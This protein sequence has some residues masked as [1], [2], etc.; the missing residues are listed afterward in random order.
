MKNRLLLIFSAAFALVFASLVSCNSSCE[1]GSGKAVSENR[2]L[3]AFTKINISGSYKIVLKQ[4]ESAVKVTADD[5]LLH[6]IETDVSGDELTIKNKKN[7]CNAGTMEID[8][9][10]P[11]FQVIKSAN[12]LDLSSDGKL[13]LKDFDM[14]F[15]GASKVKL[16]LNAANVKIQTSG[17]A[18]INLTG[19]ATE[20][21]VT[22]SGAGNLNALD[23]I[24][25]NYRVE[26]SGITHCKIN[27]LKELTVNI[28][29]TG[30]LEYKGNPAKIS[31]QHSGLTSIK[32]ID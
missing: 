31:N 25:A 22:M 12:A 30:S 6:F 27:V 7:I 10:N 28:N 19:Q 8:I 29:G 2:K 32:K 20:N 3:E 14:E 23:F 16:D 1:K 18:D 21:Q 15:G 9:S 17:A 13:S 11:D 24:V 26:T 5:N 4:G